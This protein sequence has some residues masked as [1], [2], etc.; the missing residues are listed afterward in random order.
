[1]NNPLLLTTFDTPF[2]TIPF[3]QIK[4][5]HYKPAFEAS[6]ETAKGE[7]ETIINNPEKATFTNTI[8]AL[9]NS[10]SALDLVCNVFFNLNS[11]ETN[12][13]M[14]ALAQEMSPILSEHSSNILLN[15]KLFE[16]I[17]AV[18]NSQAD[19]NLNGEQTMLLTKTYKSFVRNGALLNEADKETAKQLSKD[20]SL[21]SLQFGQNLLAE[22]KGFELHITAEKD[23][24]GL[25]ES[26][27][28]AAAATAKEKSLEGWVFTMDYPSYIPFMTYAS[29]RELRE[30]M[31]RAFTARANNGNE[32]DNKE[33]VLKI[34]QL[35]AQKAKLLGYETHAHYI[36]EER[37]A[38]SPDKVLS[39]L[40]TINT[41]SFEKAQEEAQE[42][43]VFANSLNGPSELQKWDVSYY[44]EQL[45]A[46]TL[47]FDTEK[48]KPYFQLE[49]VI[50]GVFQVTNK[51][52]GLNF[53]QR[54]DIPVY[55]EDVMTYEV[56]DEKGELVAIF[57]GDFFPRPGKRQ[58][59]WMTSFKEQRIDA[60]GNHRPHVVNVCN[61]TKPTPTKPSLLTFE[62]VTTLFHEFGHGLHG[63][64]AD[65]Q[66]GS[67][68]GTSVLWDFVEL[69][70]QIL[71]NWCYEKECLDLFAK[72]YETGETIPQEYIDQIKASLTFR[73]GSFSLRQVSFG[74][75]DMNWHGTDLSTVNDVEEFE[76][77]SMAK[78]A[79]YPAIEGAC[80]STQFGHIFQG[81]YS[82]GYYS[83]K[84]AEVLDADAFESFK[85]NGL[86]D[87]ATAT[88]F[89]DNILSKGGTVAPEQLYQQF[90]GRDA[91][92]KALLRRS[93]LAK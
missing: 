92:P 39:F 18:Y 53:T 73:T 48:L 60:N 78:T 44:A 93:G 88:A 17:K 37:M 72:H 58:G 34:A 50:D 30:K 5:E 2:E 52:F 8:E 77:S 75:L 68:S 38:K 24:A 29:N 62:E 35:R 85:E 57:Y 13:E 16:R 46:K 9:E 61:F 43:Q 15:D 12:D 65:T 69:P 3:D 80:M 63:M 76:Q 59:A 41:A 28:E 91:D 26:A 33:N 6:I 54:D 83:Y 25:P 81:G 7:V 23:L 90:K 47:N 79:L 45:K 11:A 21:L 71:E 49:K 4:I 74:T 20:L 10:G 82:A 19:F 1:M 84:W 14:Q 51:L 36:L 87:K 89:K 56:T 55:H 31:Y 32:F 86:F 27:R 42:L 66:Y 67:L 70:S 40:D 64:L 22:N